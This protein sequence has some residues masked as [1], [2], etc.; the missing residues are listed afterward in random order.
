MIV[1]MRRRKQKNKDIEINLQIS[2]TH[3]YALCPLP[4]SISSTKSP[5]LRPW[6]LGRK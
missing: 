5:P 3:L 6:K 2:L 1:M 4:N